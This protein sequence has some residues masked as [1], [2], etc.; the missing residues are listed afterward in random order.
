[1]ENN[2]IEIKGDDFI[3][4][5][6]YARPDNMSGCA[7]YQDIGFGNR[8]LLH[9]NAWECLQKVIPILRQHHLKMKIC[10]AY[11]PPLAHR[12]LLDIIPQE[13]FFARSPELSQHC[14]GTAIDVVLTDG[15]GQELEYP[16]AVDGYT[17][18]FAQEVQR[19]NY[20][21]FFKHLQKARHD[22]AEAS[23]QALQNRKFLCDLMTEAGFQ[24]LIH[25]WWHYNLPNGKD[26]DH[27]MIEWPFERTEK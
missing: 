24:P 4:D 25:E 8:A 26:A 21:A 27:P 17:K 5:V 7:V 23:K 13:G 2:L 9:K 22:F 18:E 20:E 1:M 19:G 15:N 11:R 12:K 3:I 6:M 16:T 14:H 10:D